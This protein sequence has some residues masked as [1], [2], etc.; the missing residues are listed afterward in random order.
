MCRRAANRTY[1]RFAP[2]GDGQ[3]VNRR[4]RDDRTGRVRGIIC[5]NCNGGLGRSRDSPVGPAG[6]IT[7][8]R[9]TTWQR[10]LIH[11]GVFQMCSPTRGRPPSQRS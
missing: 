4:H 2:R 9:G 3:A 7:Y 10:V 1:V 11:P 8:L 5:F 6:A